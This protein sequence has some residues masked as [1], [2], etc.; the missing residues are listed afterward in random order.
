MVL[1]HY[2]LKLGSLAKKIYENKQIIFKTPQGHQ[3]RQDFDARQGAEPFQ[4]Q[5][6]AS[7]P[8]GEKAYGFL[9]YEAGRYRQISSIGRNLEVPIFNYQFPTK[10]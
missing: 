8:A 7:I 3:K 2:F 6:T 9:T 4:R 5:S 10:E 1:G